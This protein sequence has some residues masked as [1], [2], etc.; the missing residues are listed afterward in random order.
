VAPA[1]GLGR[2]GA[3]VLKSWSRTNASATAAQ[4]PDTQVARCAA[5]SCSI[6]GV[7]VV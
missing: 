5:L 4:L 3:I 7:M 1:G 2:Y 6:S